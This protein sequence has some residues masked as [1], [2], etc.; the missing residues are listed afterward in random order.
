MNAKFSVNNLAFASV[1]AYE[2]NEGSKW[3]RACGLLFA[4]CLY[5]FEISGA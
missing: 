3:I 5:E 2:V 4:W 1:Q